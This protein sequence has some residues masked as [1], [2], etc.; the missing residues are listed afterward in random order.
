MLI[1]DLKNIVVSTLET[2]QANYGRDGVRS[3][4]GDMVNPSK[5][6]TTLLLAMIQRGQ[7]SHALIRTAKNNGNVSQF[8]MPFMATLTF[9]SMFQSCAAFWL[10]AGDPPNAG[11]LTE[12]RQSVYDFIDSQMQMLAICIGAT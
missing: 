2:W 10:A 11:D 9:E 6:D 7:A 1:D 4:L 5:L 8:V 12:L 3:K